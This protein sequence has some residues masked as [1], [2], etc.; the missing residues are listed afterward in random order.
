MHKVFLSEPRI[1]SYSVFL[2]LGLIGGYLLARWRA[3]R[4]GMKASHIDNLALLIAIFSLFG[5]RL[6]SWLFYFPPGVSLWTALK[7]TGGGMVF[8]GGLLFGILTAVVY[9]RMARLSLGDLFDVFSPGLALGLALGRVGC[10]MA[11]CCWGDVCLSA[12]DTEKVAKLT[13]QIRTLPFVSA[14]NFPL[15]VR[16]PQGSGAFEQHRTLKL[17]EDNAQLSKPVHPVQLY[18]AG[19]VLALCIF[20]HQCF[21]RRRWPGQIF[22]VLIF[23]Y[24]LIRFATEFFR[25]DNVPAYFALTLSQVI[26]II[27]GAVAACILRARYTTTVITNYSAS[28]ESVESMFVDSDRKKREQSS[29]MSRLT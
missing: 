14:P 11:G 19:L 22:W 18:E 24:A 29:A 3:V 10:F 20:L 28:P 13:W 16:F 8:Y 27:S 26:S 7:D 21:N 1:G 9:A 12:S 15:A 25:A 17:I 4:I 6:F 2:L 5:A 23:S